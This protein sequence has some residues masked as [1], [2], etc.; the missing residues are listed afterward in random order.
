[1]ILLCCF[2]SYPLAI[3]GVASFFTRKKQCTT[4]VSWFG[5]THTTVLGWLQATK[6]NLVDLTYADLV[7]DPELAQKLGDQSQQE[8]YYAMAIGEGYGLQRPV[9]WYVQKTWGST[10]GWN[11]CYTTPS[12]KELYI[13]SFISFW[14]MSWCACQFHVNELVHQKNLAFLWAPNEGACIHKR[15]QHKS[16]RRENQSHWVTDVLQ[17]KLIVVEVAFHNGNS[18]CGNSWNFLYFIQASFMHPLIVDA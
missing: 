9:L 11:R 8:L 12:P 3:N 14:T 10:F 5:P 7:P 2:R 15:I 17:L 16:V 4:S 13:M 18:W 1:M 6:W